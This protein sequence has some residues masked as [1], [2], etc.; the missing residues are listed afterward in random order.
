MSAR[1]P[2]LAGVELGGTKS[3]AALARDG[4]ILQSERWPTGDD[5]QATLSRI[6]DWF[7]SAPFSEPVAAIGIGSFGPLCLD[8]ASSDYGRIVNT[9][10]P[11][12]AG[13]DVLGR[14]AGGR[15]V[16]AGFDTDV[17]GAALAEGRWGASTGCSVHV[18]LTIGTG[19]G[20]GVVVDG[21]PLHGLLHPEIGHIR[22]RRTASDSFP[23]ICPFHGDCLEGLASGP[24]IAARAG[25]PAEALSGTDPVWEN[26][27]DHLAELMAMLILTLS[28]QRIVIGGGVAQGHSAL[29][30]RVHIATARR[31]AGYL[32]GLDPHALEAIIVPPA[33]GD[34][35]GILGA[36]ALA[37]SALAR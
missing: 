28:P 13:V 3:I 2:L 5:A 9:P 32:A 17:A 16:P 33:L 24:A 26:V 25:L 23:G 14:L 27:A 22:I 1:G 30:P 12:W 4:V 31:L 35:A 7:D 18:Y 10:K 20:G 15:N 36:I 37:D 8:P 6:N 11:G 34:K 21:K 19:I 29:L